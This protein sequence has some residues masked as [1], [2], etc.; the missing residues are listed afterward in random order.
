MNLQVDIQT[1]CSEPVP[2]EDD[3]R[4]WI[5]AALSPHRKEAEVS[6]RLVGE[7]EMTE[8]NG[9][10]RRQHKAT[11]VL[12]F[13]AE[14]PQDVPHPLLGDIIVCAAV[15]AREAR[16]QHKTAEA[17]WTHMLVHGSLHL[18][19]YDH[20]EAEDAEIMESLETT[21]LRSL[22]CACPYGRDT[23]LANIRSME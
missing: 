19:G 12:S 14:L 2:E 13:P 4:R 8:L 15:V 7:P 10:Y 11:N 22:G 20:I 5:E 1:A 18:L 16:E 17:H 9:S 23:P 6:V 3:I 21:I